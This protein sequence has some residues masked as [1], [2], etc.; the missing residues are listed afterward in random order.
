M[1]FFAAELLA[2]C[3]TAW[4]PVG[5]DHWQNTIPFGM[6]AVLIG[7][8]APV[9]STVANSVSEPAAGSTKVYAVLPIM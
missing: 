2:V 3:A 9:G 8:G 6:I 7:H 4:V 1:P 5:F